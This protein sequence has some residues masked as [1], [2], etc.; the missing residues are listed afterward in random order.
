MPG[1]NWYKYIT[2]KQK[3]LKLPTWLK[4]AALDIGGFCAGYVGGFVAGGGPALG[5]PIGIAVGSTL[6][7]GLSGS[8]KPG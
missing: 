3:R 5:V 2:E 1:A 4:R 6:G 7:S 8:V